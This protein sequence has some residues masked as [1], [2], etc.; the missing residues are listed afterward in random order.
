MPEAAF[1]CVVCKVQGWE[2]VRLQ[3]IIST[4]A[5]AGFPSGSA[6]VPR[7]DPR[8]RGSNII[9]PEGCSFAPWRADAESLKGGSRRSEAFP[10]DRG[11]FEAH[12]CPRMAF[13]PLV[14]G[15][16]L[17]KGRFSTVNYWALLLGGNESKSVKAFP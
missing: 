10:L 4:R 14:Q 6:E 3:V 1:A 8:A 16:A 13:L 5:G 17:G 11:I 2:S 9:L 7:G 12:I 15:I